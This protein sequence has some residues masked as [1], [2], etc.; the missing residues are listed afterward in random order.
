MDEI[1]RR[2]FPKIPAEHRS[3]FMNLYLDVVWFGVLTGS[4]VTF[5]SVYLARIGASG[6]H[7]GLLNASPALITMLFALPAGGW[8]KNRPIDSVVFWTALLHRIFYMFWIPLPALFGTNFQTWMTIAITL[9][10]SIPGTALAV[11]FNALFAQ[12]VPVEWRNSVSGVRNA[13]LA[14][15][16][17]LTSLICGFLLDEL[18]NPLGYQI[19]FV[20]G[21]IGAILSSL[22]LRFVRVTP[23]SEMRKGKARSLGG[24]VIPGMFRSIGDTSRSAVGLRFLRWLSHPH[25]HPL[26]LLKS[27]FGLILFSFF[28]FHTMQ[29]L[30]VPLY[31]LYYVNELNLNDQQISL[32][33]A[34]FYSFLFIS[35]TQLARIINWLGLHKATALGA[36][37]ISVFPCML[38]LSKGYPM[39]LVAMIIAGLISSL[40]GIA[41]S[42][43]LLEIIPEEKRPNYLAWYTLVLNAAILLGSLFG[44]II[45]KHRGLVTAMVMVAVGR[46]LSAAGIYACGKIASNHKPQTALQTAGFGE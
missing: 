9:I 27:P 15:T 46:A 23:Q 33:N 24:L 8:M 30:A 44:P 3:N 6:F 11:G 14:L 38:V 21:F 32:G 42:N 22:H 16:T 20:I 35:S 19:V 5:L 39:F 37:L 17:T 43:Y 40:H 36:L 28:I 10:M 13:I 4:S 31:P 2:I 1:V 26:G 45:A 41:L 7:I 34:F 18:P 12:A 29:Y 25:F